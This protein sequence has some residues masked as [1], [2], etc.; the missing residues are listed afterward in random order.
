MAMD[1]K[2]L[3]WKNY[4]FYWYP[5]RRAFQ[6]VGPGLEAEPHFQVPE[7]IETMEPEQIGAL[8]AAEVERRG[9]RKNPRNDN[10]TEPAPA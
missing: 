8:I 4:R 5:D 1:K 7:S 6:I 9:G 10:G 2:Y 3:G